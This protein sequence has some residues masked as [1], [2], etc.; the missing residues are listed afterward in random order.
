MKKTI[1]VIS[2]IFLVL[3]FYSYWE[4]NLGEGGTTNEISS[5][6]YHK[7]VGGMGNCPPDDFCTFEETLYES[8]EYIKN[9]PSAESNM[10]R[11]I[12]RKYFSKE[13]LGKIGEA[14]ESSGLLLKDCSGEKPVFDYFV[15][16]E[17]F[18]GDKNLKIEFPNCKEEME[19][20]DRVVADIAKEADR[21]YRL[22]ISET[23]QGRYE[24][25]SIGAG[26]LH[27]REKMDENGNS[28]TALFMGLWINYKP[29]SSLNTTK[30]VFEGDNFSVGKYNIF[31]K[32]IVSTSNAET[33][34]KILS[35]ASGVSSGYVTLY[36]EEE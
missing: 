7:N 23:T 2:V 35:G 6:L 5:F 29:D 27:E 10:V 9:D 4:E 30:T 17:I 8:G 31:I 21:G 25:I 36:I 18:Y 33:K 22:T 1:A 26:N 3:V 19:A 16:H 12:T 14:I 34:A 11:N 32:E 28:V 15:T 24:D 13:D 20:I